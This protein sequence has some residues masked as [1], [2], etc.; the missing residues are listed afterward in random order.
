MN[1]W[2]ALQM[3]GADPEGEATPRLLL[4]LFIE[5]TPIPWST[6][7]GSGRTSYSDPKLI[8]WR[9]LVRWCV[10]DVYRGAPSPN[11]IKIGALFYLP[12]PPSWSGKRTLEAEH[13]EIM[14]TKKPDLTNLIKALEDALQGIVYVGD[15]QVIGAGP[16]TGKRYGATP[17]VMLDVYEMPGRVVR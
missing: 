12:V 11:A 1:D 5:G 9:D 2:Q 16:G 4:S 3:F 14:H 15:Q 17:G 7:R 6:H 13:G 8:S 10:R